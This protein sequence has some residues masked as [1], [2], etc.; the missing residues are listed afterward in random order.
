MRRLTLN[1]E[2][3]IPGKVLP[4]IA[5]SHGVEEAVLRYRAIVVTTLRQMR[6]LQNTRIHIVSQPADAT[7]AIRFWLLPR[8]SNQWLNQDDVFH[9]DGWEIDFG[10]DDATYEIEATGNPL[11]PFMSARWLH[12][13]MLGLERKEHRIIG[14][15]TGGGN[16]FTAQTA[17]AGDR[18]PIRSLPELTIIQTDDDWQNALSTPLGPALKKAIKEERN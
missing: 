2:E 6:G 15:A 7:E 9:S 11:C 14:P 12:T 18:T 8:L 13:G 3:P 17:S 5:S 16:Y 1:I 10:R 4:D